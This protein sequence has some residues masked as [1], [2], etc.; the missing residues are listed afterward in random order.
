VR[1]TIETKTGPLGFAILPGETI[2]AAGLRQGIALPYECATGTCGT[3][4]ARLLDG[5]IDEGWPQAPGRQGLKPARQEFLMCQ[6][7]PLSDCRIALSDPLA[8][9]RG[10][11][12]RPQ[13]M[14]SRVAELVPLTRDMLA[15]SLT[16]DRPMVFE[17]GQYVLLEAPATAGFRAYSMANWQSPSTRLDFIIKRKPDGGFSD[18]LFTQAGV[19]HSLRLFGPLGS[20]VLEPALGHDLLVVVGGS[21]LAVA[22]SI[23]APAA[24]EGVLDR[25]RA[26]LYFGVRAMQ[27]APLLER[28]SE[29]RARFGKTFAAT[30]ALSETS[31]GEADREGWPALCFAD[32]LVHDVV[33]RDLAQGGA[34]TMAFLAGPPA[35]VDATMRVVMLKGRL[36]P[37]R[38]RF[39]KFS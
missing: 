19:G 8:A 33:G 6:A 5:R 16:L 12:E 30:V 27:D 24:A 14:T 36:P 11:A 26:Q 28:I 34:N 23:V 4:R 38:I 39:D 18:W 25:N 31:V 1:V 2:L 37:S 3:C 17:A 29:W 32:G 7:V 22:L 35:M 13:E 10:G 9:W 20:A 21:G 15:L